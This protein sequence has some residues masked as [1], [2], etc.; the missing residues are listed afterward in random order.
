MAWWVCKSGP[1]V[2]SKDVCQTDQEHTVT[3]D[4]V[5]RLAHVGNPSRC[6]ETRRLTPLKLCDLLEPGGSEVLRISFAA[7]SREC[8]TDP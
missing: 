7:N 5:A 6:M 1:P 2:S 4:P 3:G 8:R